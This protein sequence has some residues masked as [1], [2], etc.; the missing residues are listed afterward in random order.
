MMRAQ[1]VSTPNRGSPLSSLT[2]RGGRAIAQAWH[3][4]WDS[5]AR[6]ATVEILHSLDDRTLHDIGICRGEITSLVYGGRSH[7]GRQYDEAWRWRI[8]L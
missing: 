6:R 3:R 7:R 8:G 1:F 2:A 5:R 4:Y